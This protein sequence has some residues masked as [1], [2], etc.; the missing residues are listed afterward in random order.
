MTNREIITLNNQ[1]RE[2]EDG[3]GDSLDLAKLLFLLKKSIPVIIL[4]FI[5]GITTSYIIVRY[6]KPLYQSESV[7]K[8]DFESKA[9]SLGLVQNSQIQNNLNDISGEIELLKSRLFLSRVV[10]EINYPVSY[11]FYGTYLTD[12]KYNSSPIEVSFKIKNPGFY[13]RSIDI[14]LTNE[15]D[16]ELSF[17]YGDKMF[18]KTYQFGEEISTEDFNFLIEKTPNFQKEMFGKYFF[19]INSQEALIR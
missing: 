6:T 4:L 13:D 9:N 12:E 14:L 19:K 2:S 15:K 3:G 7:I 8:L 18:S 16:F 17:E 11:H 1:F 10:S 5:A